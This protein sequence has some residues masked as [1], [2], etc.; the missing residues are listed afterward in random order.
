MAADDSGQVAGNGGANG[1]GA[2]ARR[3]GEFVVRYRWWVI[4]ATVLFAFGSAYGSQ[5]LQFSTHYR[6]YFGPNNPD[7]KAFDAVQ[8]IYMKNE[9]LMF[10][11]TAKGT[12]KDGVKGTV[13]TRQ[14]L[15]AI[16]ELTK[17]SW[18]LPF[19]RRVDS[20]AN[21]QH[22]KASE[23]ELIVRD[24]IKSALKM[25][26]VQI[27]EA[28][29]IALSEPLLN[30]RLIRKDSKTTGVNVTVLMPE[31]NPDAIFKIVDAGRALAKD[32]EKKYPTVAVRL[33]G[34]V[35]LNHAFVASSQQD[36]ATLI[37]IAFLLILVLM[38]L[39]LR[40][41]LCTLGALA[42]IILSTMTAMGISGY[43]GIPLSPPAINAPLI[44]MTLAIADSI[45]F[46]VTMFHEM[47]RGVPKRDAVIE[48]LR[49]NMLPIIL[50]SVTTAIGFLTM[51]FSDA[52][53][54]HDLGNITA[55][56][57]MGALLFSVTFLP[58]LMVVLPIKA[59][60]PREGHTAV[61]A[62][63]GEFVV[64]RRNPLLYGM[65]LL[66]VVCIAFI[67]RIELNDRFVQYFDTS[68]QFRVDAD[69]TMQNLTGMYAIE[70]SLPGAAPGSKGAANSISSPAYLKNLGKFVDWLRAQKGVVHV[71]AMSDTMKRLNKNLNGDKQS[72]Y[73]LP[74]ERKLAA[75]YLL[76][77]E[78]SLP[79]GLDLN[80]QINVGKSST[81][82]VVTI[83]DMSAVAMRAFEVKSNKWIV[84]NLPA[85]MREPVRTTRINPE[86]GKMLVDPKTG[87]PVVE[88]AHVH[89]RGTGANLM[90]AHISERNIVSMLFGTLLALLLISA[91][92][93]VALRSVKIGLISLIPNLVP[94]AMAFG[95]WGLFVG[96]VNLAAA[97]LAA[98][99]LGI[100]VDDTIHFLS[101]YLRA[102]REQN[103][104]VEDAVRY[105]FVTVGW[106]LVVTTFVL[107]AGFGVLAYSS[108]AINSIMGLMT[109]ITI[110]IALIADFFF[111]APLLLKIDRKKEKSSHDVHQPSPAA[112]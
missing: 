70:Y 29:K 76:L 45:H 80:D 38:A 36:V 15:A 14:R 91:L 102:R 25:P 48:S 49:I 21:F 8:R 99:T 109:A 77:F 4:I 22:T 94:A 92:L 62:H 95:A 3:W 10:V 2:Y 42:V 30:G 71:N 89:G 39:M 53:P 93:M 16:E 55:I 98:L 107:M 18:K 52:P 28:Q 50:T 27:V 104:S 66:I 63:V 86:T 87:K 81:R 26:V 68:V 79:F 1:G 96:E 19:S 64:R 9:N 23:D 7:L 110:F 60:Q 61:M 31:N 83:T 108:F 24:L 78:M 57:I 5:F 35:M 103:A 54:F 37:P 51:N 67:P 13:F 47:R 97:V 90:F 59:R 74:G 105:A 12:D 40:S 33:T 43:L 65:G 6:V 85:Y 17:R 41:L 111:L 106:A 88:V 11:V 58:A 72:F 20:L 100:V 69:Y 82:I 34:I 75:Q 101:K 112:A 46:L 84:D 44:I 73:K 56:G 32:I